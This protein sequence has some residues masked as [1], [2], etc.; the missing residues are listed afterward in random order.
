MFPAVAAVQG[1]VQTTEEALQA[2][3]PPQHPSQ[4]VLVLAEQGGLSLP[5]SVPHHH[6]FEGL[7]CQDTEYLP[8]LGQLCRWTVRDRLDK[9]RERGKDETGRLV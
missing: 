9:D 3:P 8:G 6:R 2:D 7:L 1:F 4:G 5:A